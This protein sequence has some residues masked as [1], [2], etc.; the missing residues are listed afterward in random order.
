MQEL[1]EKVWSNPRFH[2][3]FKR[4][5]LAWLVKELGVE[6]DT[7]P[8]L[9]EAAKLMQAAAILACSESQTHRLAAFR[10]ATC[11]YEYFGATALP[12]DQ[13]LRVVLA[14]LG[15]YPSITTR[16]DVEHSL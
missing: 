10:A 15:N 4:I 16:E 12:F 7:A 9:S 13:A 1:S 14:R 11:A 6:A 8:Q 5:E 2:E 3:A